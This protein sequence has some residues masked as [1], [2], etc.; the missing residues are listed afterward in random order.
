MLVSEADSTSEKKDF[1]NFFLKLLD[2][3]LCGIKFKVLGRTY[4]FAIAWPPFYQPL[5][6]LSRGYFL[7]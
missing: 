2:M 4:R 1:Y 5:G 3:L 7:R 6:T